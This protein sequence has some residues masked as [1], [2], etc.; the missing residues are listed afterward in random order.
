MKDVLKS[1]LKAA[2]VPKFGI[3][4]ARAFLV[5]VD[6]QVAAEPSF[7]KERVKAILF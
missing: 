4:R 5:K 2:H 3:A 6:A 7:I 1:A